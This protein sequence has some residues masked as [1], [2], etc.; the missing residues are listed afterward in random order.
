MGLI[1][2]EGFW[3]REKFADQDLTIVRDIYAND[4]YRTALIRERFQA[5][6]TIIDVGAH[7][8]VFTKLAAELAP[9]ARITAIEGEPKNWEALEANV[10]PFRQRVLI[11]KAV[12]TY[13]PRPLR[14]WSAFT[15]HG[16]ESTGGGA[17]RPWG[18]DV[19]ESR[20]SASEGRPVRVNL[21][22]Y[23]SIDLLKLDCEGSEFSIV[24]NADLSRIG[25]ILGEY[26][27]RERWEWL[28]E[29]RCP[30]WDYGHMSASG[31]LG[32]FHLRNPRWS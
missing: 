7:I 24:G 3:I 31:D 15:D 4:A 10:A 12:C 16:C 18:A 6:K 17:V 26:H 23:P 25:F 32:N 28:R 14:W 30:D 21:D 1:L 29:I 5:A 20:Y 22:S 8:G 27:G 9:N 13:D 19:D 11:V 2:R